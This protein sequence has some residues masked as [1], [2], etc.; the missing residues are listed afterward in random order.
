[1]K[2]MQTLWN[3]RAALLK[4]TRSAVMEQSF[5][6]IINDSIHRIHLTEINSVLPFRAVYCLDIGCGW[7]RIASD[8]VRHNPYVTISGIDLSKNFVKLFNKH[9][10]GRGHAIVGDMQKLPFAKHI[11][12]VVY[13][14]VSL[15]YLSPQS[16]RKK[17]FEEMLRVLKKE[18]KLIL[19]EPNKTGVE[20]VRLWGLVPYVYRLITKRTKVET[21]GSAFYDKEIEMLTRSSGGIVVS[22][23]TYPFFSIMLLPLIIVGTISPYAA[24]IL[25]WITGKFDKLLPIGFPSYFTTWI[26]QKA[27]NNRSMV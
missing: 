13:C 3:K 8:L 11:F 6:W 18:G 2:N 25:I 27:P 14:I 1:M 9:L 16:A 17:A 10:K 20:I 12:D 4:D 15:M 7:G 26:I 21:Y 19:I 5:P 23:R 24:S 22:K